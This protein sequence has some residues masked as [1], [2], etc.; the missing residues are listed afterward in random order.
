MKLSR[1][2]I[3]KLLKTGNQSRRRFRSKSLTNK[4]LILDVNKSRNNTSLTPAKTKAKT[5]AKTEKKH[6]QS[7]KKKRRG[8]NLRYK[9]LKRWGGAGPPP[10]TSMPGKK[11]LPLPLPLPLPVGTRNF[12][13][14]L[15]V[16]TRPGSP[17]PEE[18]T[19]E[20]TEAANIFSAYK[21]STDETPSSSEK[22]TSIEVK[23]QSTTPAQIK[24]IIK[25]ILDGSHCEFI[26]VAF[27]PHLTTYINSD[28]KYK[29]PYNSISPT[30]EAF[31][32]FPYP[33]Q[34][35]TK[36]T[37]TDIKKFEEGLVSAPPSGGGV[38]SG[39]LSL[40]KKN[41]LEKL[42]DIKT[43]LDKLNE[44]IGQYTTFFNSSLNDYSQND[45]SLNDVFGGETNVHNRQLLQKIL[46]NGNIV[47]DK[48][49]ILK[50]YGNDNTKIKRDVFDK[51]DYTF[52]N[53]LIEMKTD[54][55]DTSVNKK[56]SLLNINQNLFDL[57]T[58]IATR[59]ND[60]DA[61]SDA[62]LA[63]TKQIV[64]SIPQ[65]TLENIKK[66]SFLGIIALF[67]SIY[68]GFNKCQEDF[69]EWKKNY[70]KFKDT[71]EIQKIYKDIEKTLA[72]YKNQFNEGTIGGISEIRTTVANEQM[73]VEITEAKK[74]TTEAIN[75]EPTKTLIDKLKIK[76]YLQ[77]LAYSFIVPDG[78]LK[79]DIEKNQCIN[80]LN[81]IKNIVAKKP[82]TLADVAPVEAA[83][84]GEAAAPSVEAS[85][86]E[87]NADSIDKML[88][89]FTTEPSDSIDIAKKKKL[90]QLLTPNGALYEAIYTL[91]ANLNRL[92]AKTMSNGSVTE[93]TTDIYD[94]LEY[95]IGQKDLNNIYEHQSGGGDDIE[96][97]YKKFM[98][99]I[100]DKIGIVQT[101]TDKATIEKID[102]N[103][104]QT[105]P[106]P[107]E[108]LSVPKSS[109]SSIQEPSEQSNKSAPKSIRNA[110]VRNEQ[111]SRNM[112]IS[113]KLASTLS[114]AA[115]TSAATSENA[116]GEIVGL[117][118]KNEPS[119]DVILKL[120]AIPPQAWAS[121]TYNTTEG[122]I[123]NLG[124]DMMGSNDRDKTNV[125]L[126]ILQT[127]QKLDEIEMKLKP[128]DPN[129]LVL[130]AKPLD[131]A[132]KDEIK[133]Q[134]EAL[135][136]MIEKF[137]EYLEAL[138]RS[139][140]KQGGG[141]QVGGDR[142]KRGSFNQP[143]TD[144]EIDLLMA[145][146]KADKNIKELFND[147]NKT[148]SFNVVSDK[149]IEISIE[150]FK[151]DN[152]TNKWTKNTT[153]P[154]DTKL[155]VNN[156]QENI[157]NKALAGKIN[158]T[159]TPENL[160]IYMFAMAFK[161]TSFETFYNNFIKSEDKSVA[162]FTTKLSDWFKDTTGKYNFGSYWTVLAGGLS[163][164]LKGENENL[165]QKIE[166]LKKELAEA[167]A[168]IE[169]LQGNLKTLN[170]DKE[171][172]E[173]ELTN[174]KAAAAAAKADI[175]RL[176]ADQ[177]TKQVEHNAALK[178]LED[179]KNRVNSELA[180]LQSSTNQ[181]DKE[182]TADLQKQ[183]AALDIQIKEATAN[184]ETE[185]AELNTKLETLQRQ[186][187]E[188]EAENAAAIEAKEVELASITKE[189]A[190]L[191]TKIKEATEKN[192]TSTTEMEDLQ[193]KLQ[194]SQEE[195]VT[196]K[197]TLETT[198]KRL[199]EKET[200]Y[201]GACERNFAKVKDL[202]QLNEKLKKDL[203]GAENK[204][205]DS[206]MS[207]VKLLDSHIK[208]YDGFQKEI[209]S[210]AP[211]V[212][213]LPESAS[214]STDESNVESDT[215]TG[216]SATS[217]LGDGNAPSSSDKK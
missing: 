44:K 60:V 204:N 164:P 198:K 75:D 211:A 54:D 189:K 51:G 67:L 147:Q 94:L 215:L 1:N 36:A 17:E 111:I 191:E 128:T 73:N 38:M 135:N 47:Y 202:E 107:P 23:T 30:D 93:T 99:E 177:T 46:K 7:M 188:K 12:S 114:S 146:I 97:G 167:N 98:D 85:A 31:M 62:G 58:R 29:K 43:N 144:A 103:A 64:E 108:Q 212:E 79:T 140:N 195:L 156:L 132:A 26:D 130:T 210:T 92:R 152:N 83:V 96:V 8:L 71:I 125:L 183:K 134:L 186:L 3:A 207:I 123:R 45:I 19:T 21:K 126:D 72:E 127:E 171:A 169:K 161:H 148:P 157:T 133:K 166:N 63:V 205:F 25:S 35:T 162:N 6:R 34:P 165:K 137:K 181:T 174:L 82:I 110:S 28:A 84:T 14:D 160:N 115:S 9:T 18:L 50:T 159:N 151:V 141:G 139:E 86:P 59:M 27:V 37:S 185:K 154:Y 206:K 136:P 87:I 216:K 131:A 41:P 199:G 175:E 88:Q 2:K 182:K 187:K 102:A 142:T 138:K 173:A 100:T 57:L 39:G 117:T 22:T 74:L 201:A 214:K 118:L 190:E 5:A 180:K 179:E 109:L 209:N 145:A 184:F 16:L 113:P 155:P 112:D 170:T 163:N 149:L 158:N 65:I 172:K 129:P 106:F 119:S 61:G 40:M 150:Y 104:Q 70:S 56:S 95:V 13:T 200:E 124:A 4:D 176:T 101:S 89:L 48:N 168:T 11:P 42:N 197:T 217:K 193:K 52:F 196:T 192:T 32:G 91:E 53:E 105:Q 90:T 178:L 81:K 78:S 68:T 153:L 10:P 77:Y 194:K 49:V 15:N 55:W 122:N 66:K 213:V 24:Q 121:T 33:Q 116:P 69:D 80:V 20:E 203:E 120:R 208:R 143:P 76:Y